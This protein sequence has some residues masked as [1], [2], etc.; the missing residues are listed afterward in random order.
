MKKIYLLLIAALFSLGAYSQCTVTVNSLTPTCHGNCDGFAKAIP[1]GSTPPY[2]YSWSTTPV[3]TTQTASGLC[4]GTY[5]VKVTNASGC[6]ALKTVIIAQPAAIVLNITHLNPKCNGGTGKA[7]ANVSGGTPPYA[8]NWSTTPAQNTKIASNLAPGTYTVTVTDKKGCISTGTVTI[9]QP[10]ALAT[11]ITSTSTTC[12]GATGTALVSVTGGT[13]AYT[14]SWATTPVR[15]TPSITGLPSGSYSV[16]V[17]DSNGCTTSTLANV[18]NTSGLTAVSAQTNVSCNGGS[19]GTATINASGGTQPYTYSWSTFPS[20]STQTING[21]PAGTYYVSVKDAAGCLFTV[22]VNITQPPALAVTITHVN[23]SCTGIAS[24]SATANPTGG[25]PTYTYSWSTIPTQTT[26]TAVNLPAGTYTVTVTDQNVCVASKTVIIT[27]PATALAATIT[28]TNDKCHGGTGASATAHPT[29]GTTPY[30]YS[31]ST[32]PVGTTATAA[33]LAAGTYHLK[34]TDSKGC[35]VTDSVIITQP[36]PITLSTVSV[37]AGCGTA[38]GSASATISSGGVTPFTFSWNTTPVQ[39]TSTATALAAGVYKVTVT[40]SN[41]CR[42]T[43]N[44]TVGNTGGATVSISSSTNVSCRGGNSGS[45]TV[46]ATGG[47]GAYTYSWNTT[48]PQTTATATGLKAGTYTVTVTESN[49]CSSFAT[50]VITQ[51]ATLLTGTVTPISPSCNGGTGSAKAH[52]TGGVAA[53]TYSWKTIPVQTTQTAT[54]LSAGTFTVFV[55]DSRGCQIHDTVVLT[56]PAAITAYFTKTNVTCNGGTNGNADITPLGG[57]APYTYSWSTVPVQTTRTATGLTAGTYTVTITDSKGCIKTKT[58]VITQPPAIVLTTTTVN[59]NCGHSD[60][61]ATVAASGGKPAYTYSWNTTPAQTT[62]AI[63]TLAAGIYK[64][65][66]TDSSGCVQ[67]ATTTVNNTNAGTASMVHT[68]VTCNGLVNGTAKITLTGGTG[69]F[70]YSWNTTPSQTAATATNLGAGVYSVKVTDANGCITNDT[71]SII[72]PP[73]LT[74]TLTQTNVSCTGTANG[75]ASAAV[76]G[77][78]PAYVYSWS[79]TPAQTTA[80]ASGLSQGTYTLT[81][82]DANGCTASSSCTISKAAITATASAT[83]ESCHG[84]STGTASAHPAS[85]TGSYTYSWTTSPVQTSSTAMN[86]AAG[87]YTVFVTDSAGCTANTTATIT[88]PS[89][90]TGTTSETNVLCNGAATGTA[91]ASIAGGTPPYNYSWSTSPAQMTASAANLSAG[92]YTL[93]VMDTNNCVF[94]Q[95]ITITQAPAIVLTTTTVNAHCGQSNGSATVTASGGTGAFTYSWNTVPT[96]STATAAAITA[97]G[98]SVTVTDNSGC[99]QTATAIINNTNAAVVTTTHVNAT[100][101]TSSNGSALAMVSGGSHPFTYSWS[102][103]PSQSTAA[104][105]G[106]TPGSYTVVVTDSL[107]C[108]SAVAVLI[109][110]P[111]ALTGTITAMNVMCNGAGNGTA[112]VAATGGT[113]HYTYS[114]NT[115]PAQTGSTATSLSPGTYTVTITDSLGCSG[116]AV[117]TITQPSP[118]ALN[119]ANT[120]TS[121]HGTTDGT[122]NAVVSGGTSPYIYSWSTN[123]P[124]TTQM[125]TGLGAGTYSITVT[126]VNGCTSTSNTTIIQPVS[127][128]LATSSTPATCGN[129]DGSATVV[130]TAG[131]IAPISYS[132]S[133]GATTSVASNQGA[134]M[135]SVV[136]TDSAGCSAMDTAYISNSGLGTITFSILNGCVG[137]SNGSVSATLSGG[138]APYTYSWSTVPPQ[139]TATASGLA[140]GSY[141]VM[142]ADSFGCVVFGTALITPPTPLVVDSVTHTLITCASCSNATAKITL[143][144]GT[145]PYSYSWSTSPAQTTQTAVNLSPGLYD[146]CITDAS[147]CTICDSVSIDNTLG[148]VVYEAGSSRISVYPNPSSGDL[149]VTIQSASAASDVTLKLVNIV[150]Q[151]IYS[152]RIELAG[153]AATREFDFSN[154][155]KGLY[156][157][158]LINGREVLTQKLILK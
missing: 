134:G 125:A 12:G 42:S 57:T 73:V 93:T 133:S 156:L 14:Y 77:G 91:S 5:T 120:H 116:S 110:S 68:N 29:G 150:G 4:A 46:A 55:T 147:G 31:W 148:I 10:S 122:S 70:T 130:L 80:T 40:D 136:V 129:S 146:V 38:N 84:G 141:N 149:N 9:T 128:A 101:S 153:S 151:E 7:T 114:W 65:T 157:L 15:T 113:P 144:G 17:T 1:T 140:P 22:T 108:T 111:P 44:A 33:G 28:H 71:A 121:C 41:G 36:I 59:A 20:Q 90:I 25:N 143:S 50:V 81:L 138:T 61:S 78:T 11:T 86:L 18:G 102:T 85:G 124:Q 26:K 32:V 89:A 21:L 107:G 74:A 88:Q 96:Q 6:N 145:S 155:P 39:T 23:V 27:Q 62:P 98:Y 109:S 94:N 127:I 37:S 58:V 119:T 43:A 104:A 100:C 53:Y 54:N 118:L 64:V 67:T 8:Y 69:P 19:N 13:G 79:T 154:Y 66:V 139:T 117:T 97:G 2:T 16:T 106:L 72:Q 142:I 95:T 112:T 82:T 158:Q 24:G 132:W 52:P 56:Q 3:Q 105:S 48:P 45:A 135:Y 137:V 76:T 51:P 47:T 152:T 87:T 60:G 49:G 35:S 75:S 103:V 34:V 83:N 99:V 126:D 131:G 92:S 30:T 123:P 63:S 115:I